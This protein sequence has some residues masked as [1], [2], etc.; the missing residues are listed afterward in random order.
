MGYYLYRLWY[1]IAGIVRAQGAEGWAAARWQVYDKVCATCV[2]WAVVSWWL[3]PSIAV[4]RDHG[5][6]KFAW[7]SDKG[8]GVWTDLAAKWLQDGFAN[9]GFRREAIPRV[10]VA[11]LL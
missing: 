5:H 11:L 8:D 7:T 3:T 10:Q 9:S 1:A 6:L 4:D 2:S